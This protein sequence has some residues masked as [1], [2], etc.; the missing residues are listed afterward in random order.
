MA[1]SDKMTHTSLDEFRNL[2]EKIPK[3]EDIYAVPGE[4]VSC[5]VE[6]APKIQASGPWW[7]LGG[8]IS[9]I[10]M[11]VH[12]RPT[13]IEILTDGAGMEKI[14]GAL[15]G[16][17]PT[18]VKVR[19]ARLEREAELDL[20]TYPVLER[21]NYTE[22]TLRGT[23][24]SIKG[25]CQMKVGEWEWGDALIFEPDLVN[26]SGVYVPV[27]PLGLKS[28]L[29]IMLGWLDRARMIS[30]AYT[31]AHSATHEPPPVKKSD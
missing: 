29:Y 14:L 23:K 3:P 18:P 8:D 4:F 10:M 21:S 31:L 6:I 1:V 16:Y 12:I 24:V 9:E 17:S 19:E 2:R 11:G 28:E 5:L 30:D 13:E 20:M 15:S 22:F 26:V 27:M 25:D 7:S